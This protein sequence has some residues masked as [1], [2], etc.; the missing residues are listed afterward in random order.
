[1]ATHEPETERSDASA[2]IHSGFTESCLLK[3]RTYIAE[4][5]TRLIFKTRNEKVHDNV[6]LYTYWVDVLFFDRPNHQGIGV[7][8]GACAASSLDQKGQRPAPAALAVK[9]ENYEHPLM[10]VNFAYGVFYPRGN[11]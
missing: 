2:L 10:L 9:H 4:S 11:F 7:N 3:V 6:A 5:C 1:M 8:S